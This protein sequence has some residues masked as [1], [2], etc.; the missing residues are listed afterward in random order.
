MNDDALSMRDAI[1][2]HTGDLCPIPISLL[3]E[4]RTLI[5]EDI[6][7]TSVEEAFSEMLGDLPDTFDDHLY[8]DLASTLMENCAGT[9]L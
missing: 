8:D 1:E 9:P 3:E 6:S 5:G 7:P 2:V 4:I